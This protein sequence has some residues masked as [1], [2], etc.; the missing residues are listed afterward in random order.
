MLFGN[1]FMSV[2]HAEKV[3]TDRC[4]HRDGQLCAFISSDTP[5]ASSPRAFTGRCHCCRLILWPCSP[6][7]VSWRPPRGFLHAP[8]PARM[9]VQPWPSLHHLGSSG[10][11]R[12]AVAAVAG[13]GCR[14]RGSTPPSLCC[15]RPCRTRRQTHTNPQLSTELESGFLEFSA[16]ESPFLGYICSVS[17]LPVRHS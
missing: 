5:P 14:P 8:Q 10:E 3:V 11:A 2:C 7:A 4:G 16:Q 17:G 12:A 6:T 15:L 1:C 13:R 9:R